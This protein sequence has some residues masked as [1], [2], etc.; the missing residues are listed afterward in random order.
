M[1]SSEI[2][3]GSQYKVRRY[4]KRVATLTTQGIGFDAF[5]SYWIATV[6]GREGRRY[7]I[8]WSEA[9]PLHDLKTQ[10]AQNSGPCKM[11]WTTQI[12]RDIVTPAQ[13]I[14]KVG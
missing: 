1:R 8:E 6:V 2:Q 3:I 7:V 9:A 13:I 4:N 14:E 5:W 12:I 10:M 11:E